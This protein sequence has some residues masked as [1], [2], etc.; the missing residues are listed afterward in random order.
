ML[1]ITYRMRI[2]CINIPTQGVE[3]RKST[4][5]PLSRGE[6]KN[7]LFEGETSYFSASVPAINVSY[8]SELLYL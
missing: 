6:S 4:H 7:P 1:R 2:H 3:T 8:Y 5:L